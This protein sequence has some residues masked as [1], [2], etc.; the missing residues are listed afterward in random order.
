M[1]KNLRSW[2]LA[3]LVLAAAA[4]NND[5]DLVV[6]APDVTADKTTDTLYIGD[7]TLLH[8]A[9]NVTS[10]ITYKWTV[11]GAAAGTDSVYKFKPTTSGD[12]EVIFEAS[13][14]MGKKSL[15]YRVHVWSRYENGFYMISEGFY[16]Q[17]SGDVNFYDY[18]LDTVYTYAYTAENPGK[19]IGTTTSSLQFGTVYKGKLYLVG[20][21]GG[22]LVVT[23]ANTLKETG[24][25][26]KLPGEDGRAFLG[27]DDTKGLLS[28]ASGLFPVNLTTLSLGAQVASAPGEI[29]DMI[30]S[31]NY[32]FVLSSTDGILALNASDYTLAKKLG[33]AVSG[34]VESK[35]GSVW[36][37]SATQLKKINPSTLAVDSISTGF[38]V[39]YN[40][41]TYVNS[42]I[43]ASTIDNAIYLVSGTDKVYRY[44]PGDAASLSNPF[45]TLPA[46]QYFYGKGI[47]YDKTRNN[48]VLNSNTN[49]YGADANNTIYVHNAST[50]ALIHTATY[51]GYYFPGMAIFR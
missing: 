33:T 48:L 49:L 26:D 11:N 51:T 46:G 16:G 14:S 22:P 24:R 9:V 39:H 38:P 43:A 47:A 12:F 40:E 28:T 42:S 10:G 34:F 6:P 27:V 8:P 50:G 23:D 31:G 35:D 15:T 7:S 32:I 25:I 4:C 36:A 21:F 5:D 45:I 3:G 2:L 20:K 19:M 44:I 29:R 1:H 30:R 13:N 17:K 18:G 37:A 41:W